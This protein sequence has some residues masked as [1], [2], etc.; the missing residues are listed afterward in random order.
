[1]LFMVAIGVYVLTQRNVMI[2]AA[3]EVE[4]IIHRIRLRLIDKIRKADLIPLERVGRSSIYASINKDTLTLS[5]ASQ[6]LVVGAQSAILTAFTLLYIAWLSRLAFFVCVVFILLATSIYMKRLKRMNADLQEAAQ[7][8]NRMFDLLTDLLEGFKEVRMS[9][10]R[11]SAIHSDL[12]QISEHAATKKKESQSGIARLFI[13]SQTM[14]YLLV[15]SMV[16]LVPRLGTF[17]QNIGTAYPQV[18][19]QT[20]TATLFLIGP[21]SFLVNFLSILANANSAAENI[22]RLDQTLND[23]ASV[24][25]GVTRPAIGCG[26][27]GPRSE[28]CPIRLS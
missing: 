8:E 20:A 14:F 9:P 19:I 21:V 15:A 7:E 23:A 16:F 24:S 1:M 11:S 22:E 28:R 10:A 18:V 6:S 17:F 2:T 5:Q 12:S 13:F 26:F 27:Q 3:G 25:D 4:K